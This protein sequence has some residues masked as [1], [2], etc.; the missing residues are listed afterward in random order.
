MRIRTW[1][2][3]AAL[4][5]GVGLAGCAGEE[6]E[7]VT[8][9]LITKQ[10]EN[11]YWVEMREVAQE[12][13]DDL[14][15]ELLT[16]TGESDTDAASQEAALDD[17]VEQ[18]ADGILLAPT[19]AEALDPAITR[20][21]EAGVLV[22]AVDTPTDPQ[23]AVDATFATDNERAGQLIGQYAAAKAEELG[24]EPQIATLDLTPGVTTGEQR[25]AGFLAGFGIEE[26]DEA[27][28]ASVDTEGDRDNAAVVMT[29]VLADHPDVNV[30]YTVNEPAALGALAALEDAD[31]DMDEIVMVSVD[32]GCRT[33]R[34]G[35]RPGLIDATASQYP[36]N[37]AREG[38]RAVVAAVRDGEA[39]SGYHDTGTELIS[40]SPVD[41][42]ES[43]RVEFGVRTCW[44][45]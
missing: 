42:V 25:H 16:A 15:A 21:R 31:A 1:T 28:V 17:M 4:L 32:G 26:G 7:P 35:V 22:I 43:R 38:V 11:P 3:A 40:D 39:P 27:I 34:E 6:Q 19:D 9:G 5:A 13:A 41:G 24:L 18:G 20:A 23:D 30:V 37:M 8:V 44:G 36:Q 29:Q 2:T 12:T 14:D 10:E 45:S 33:M